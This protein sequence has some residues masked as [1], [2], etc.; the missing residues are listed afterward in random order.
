MLPYIYA[1]LRLTYPTILLVLILSP[2]AICGQA[3]CETARPLSAMSDVQVI[4]TLASKNV[5]EAKQA[6]LEIV[7]RGECMI[8]L[9]LKL[10]GDKRFFFGYD[11]GPDNS[12]NHPIPQD[13]S[14][15]DSGEFTTMEVVGIYLIS[16]IYY[17]TL[18]FADTSYLTDD[19]R[20]KDHKFNTPARVADAWTSVE[21]WAV[22]VRGEGLENLRR[23]KRHPLQYTK[24][25]FWGTT[26]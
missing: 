1:K 9:L 3:R 20:P 13:N 11:L 5:E 18:N 17:D 16:A 21:Q 23:E 8:P 10:K 12:W 19:S 2:V 26:Q 25:R 15:P 7:Q 22:N 14:D 4:S 6:V 24:V